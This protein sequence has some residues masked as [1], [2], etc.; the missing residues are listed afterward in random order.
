MNR[1]LPFLI[2]LVGIIA[3]I[4]FRIPDLTLPYFWDELGVYSGGVFY[5]LDNG[6]NIFSEDIPLKYSRGHPLL[7]FF[8]HAVILKVFGA[9]L[10]VSHITS[11]LIT[12]CTVWMVFHFGKVHF[13]RSV[14]MV[15]ALTLM[16]QPLFIAQSTLMLPEMLLALLVLLSIHLFLIK[17]YWLFFISAGAAIWIKETAMIIP[18]TL[19]AST[20][21]EMNIK[22]DKDPKK[23]KIL[24]FT[25]AP[26]LFFIGFI[27]IQKLQQGWFLFPGHT[28]MVDMNLDHMFAFGKDYSKFVLWEQGRFLWLIIIGAA[29]TWGLIKKSIIIN[30]NST[31]AKKIRILIIL[32]FGFFI[33]STTFGYLNRYM[34]ILVLPMILL[35][36]YSVHVYFGQFKWLTY[37]VVIPLIVIP[38]FFLESGKFNYDVDLGFKQQIQVQLEA[39]HFLEEQN[40]QGVAISANWP[41][42]S[43][44]DDTRKGY[45]NGPRVFTPTIMVEEET[46]YVVFGKP[47]TVLKHFHKEDWI[48]IKSFEES[49]V[50]IDIFRAP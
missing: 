31:Q 29:I 25:L 14:G 48:L 47:G 6:L 1:S 8:L 35:L 34:L 17:K 11:L 2:T 41:I 20:L 39:T 50:K 40:L 28:G 36:S 42:I 16:A 46:N 32:I 37:A 27:I 45:L 33:F 26:I 23:W 4:I 49:F 9:K 38:L 19:F 15:A 30:F 44:L 13:S 3:F 18:A 21:F 7:F 10:I 43:G 5:L 22:R 24:G 12:V